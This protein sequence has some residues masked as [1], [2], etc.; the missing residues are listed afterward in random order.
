MIAAP[1]C[2]RTITSERAVSPA[3]ER[4]STTRIMAIARERLLLAAYIALTC[5]SP[6]E[7]SA[8]TENPAL[9]SVLAIVTN[10]QIQKSRR[11]PGL[12]IVFMLPRRYREFAIAAQGGAAEL[13]RQVCI[14]Q[15]QF[16]Y[17]GRRQ[18]Q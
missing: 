14:S 1:A 4:M 7:D 3:R 12:L 5:A 2:T 6:D 16:Y 9:V 13:R 8:A 18:L 17:D 10:A 11:C 15:M